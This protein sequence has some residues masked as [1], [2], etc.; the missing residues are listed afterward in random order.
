MESIKNI[1]ICAIALCFLS[2]CV[3]SGNTDESNSSA[4]ITAVGED[5]TAT[6]VVQ[7]A[8]SETALLSSKEKSYFISARKNLKSDEARLYATLGTGVADVA[9]QDARALLVKKPNNIAGLTV[10]ATSLV[11]QRKYQMAEFYANQ[12]EKYAPDNADVSNIRGL[13]ALYGGRNT[14]ADYRKALAYFEKAFHSN[15]SQIASGLNLAHLQLEMGN[16]QA[17]AETFRLLTSR[18]QDCL[19]AWIGFGVAQNRLGSYKDA[20]NSFEMA[21]S[22]QKDHPEA[23]YFLALVEKNGYNN[24]RSATKTLKHLIASQSGGKAV[25]LKAQSLLRV[26]EGEAD[27]STIAKEQKDDEN[28]MMTGFGSKESSDED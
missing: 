14:L 3:T 25:R 4:D 20:K 8:G 13:A 27:Q 5:S 23:L 28:L 26:M 2:A 6:V 22:K 24:Q 19:Q 16:A 10:L 18:N 17:A 15:A 12:L 1:S 21:L 11:L 7:Q 9:E